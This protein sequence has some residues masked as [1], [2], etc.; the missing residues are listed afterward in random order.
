[1]TRIHH[2]IVLVSF[3]VLAACGPTPPPAP[4]APAAQPTRFELAS[5]Y[6]LATDMPGAAGSALNKVIAMT[7]DPDDPSAYLLDEMIATMPDSSLK[8]ATEALE[9]FVASYVNDCLLER[10]PNLVAELVM[11][12]RELGQAAHAVGTTDSV[13]IAADGSLASHSIDGLHYV[14]DGATYDLALA[15]YDLGPVDAPA[16]EV[17]YGTGALAL[18][19]H[20]LALPY[21]QMV[22]VTLDHAIV[23]RVDSGAADLGSLLHGAVDCGAIGADIASALGAGDPATFSRM[24]GDVLT[25]AA[26][27]VYA[28]LARLDDQ[29]LVLTVTG[30]AAA[31]VG[32]DGVADELSDGTWLGTVTYGSASA[33]LASGSFTGVRE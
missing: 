1:M 2:A 24:C 14:L 32:P 9:P 26:E 31:P 11:L 16:V 17:A 20:D 7:D 30:V 28:D 13:V 4:D 25:A 19:A 21:G 5:T 10:A 27:S 22:R 8:R 33:P 29:A 23:P 3:L 6:D 18:G 15:D 12:G